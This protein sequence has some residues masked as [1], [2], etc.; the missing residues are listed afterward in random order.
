MAGQKV[1]PRKDLA[2]NTDRP[3]IRVDPATPFAEPDQLTGTDLLKCQW[4]II[5]ATDSQPIDGLGNANLGA[6][7]FPVLWAIYISLLGY[8]QPIKALKY[9]S[10]PFVYK[11]KPGVPS[12]SIDA[13]R[14]QEGMLGWTATWP[15]HT[16]LQF[17]T[18]ANLPIPVA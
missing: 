17:N 16:W 14:Y 11:V 9:N 13:A 12:I 18:L 3:E 6:A 4:N 15:Y 1:D 2:T 8:G 7:I 5:A 10:V